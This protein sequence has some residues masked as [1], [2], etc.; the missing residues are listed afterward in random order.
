MNEKFKHYSLLVIRILIG[1]AFFGAGAAKLAGVEMM[2][3]SFEAIGLGQW[4]RYITGAIEVGSAILLFV[5]GKQ[6]WGAGLLVCTMIGA[7]LAHLLILGPGSAPAIILGLLSALVAYN[8]RDQ[9]PLPNT[10]A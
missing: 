6:A 4:F 1:L 10:P 2:V 9:I 7:V 5:P 8:Y 3:A